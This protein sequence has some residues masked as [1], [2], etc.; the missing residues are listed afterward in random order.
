[1][2]VHVW[3]P[4]T[5]KAVDKWIAVQG[6]PGKKKKKKSKTLPEKLLNQKQGCGCISSSRV[7][8]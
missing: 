1:M 8:A 7:F 3:I 5:W 4:A 2:V 6:H